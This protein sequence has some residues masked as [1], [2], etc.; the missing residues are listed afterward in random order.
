MSTRTADHEL[1]SE[2]RQHQFSEDEDR[3]H[4]LVRVPLDRRHR[5]LELLPPGGDR[6]EPEVIGAI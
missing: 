6:P 5:S 4:A 1:D 2:V 3:R